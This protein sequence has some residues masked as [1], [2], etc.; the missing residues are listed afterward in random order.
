MANFK[1]LTKSDQQISIDLSLYLLSHVTC[2]SCGCGWYDCVDCIT[3][4]IMCNLILIQ[5][6]CILQ[7]YAVLVN[8][9]KETSFFLLME[10]VE[11]NNSST[12]IGFG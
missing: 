6:G 7:S 4:Q 3:H 5:C 8:H 1:D 9:C 11:V 10:T 12:T 2:E